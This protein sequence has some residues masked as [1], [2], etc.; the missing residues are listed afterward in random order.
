MQISKAIP[1]QYGACKPCG[2]RGWGPWR[3]DHGR[4]WTCNARGVVPVAFDGSNVEAEGFI[5]RP[6]AIERGTATVAEIL[7]V[8]E[9]VQDTYRMTIITRKLD[10]GI[11][12]WTTADREKA[13]A[14]M[15]RARQAC[16]RDMSDDRV[17][18][19]VREFE[20]A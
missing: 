9:S 8:K 3:W 17:S 19:L 1:T 11:V 16:G 6:R 18:E 2:G 14:A 12:R 7:V 20:L 13:S 15:L 10:G 5:A 4:C